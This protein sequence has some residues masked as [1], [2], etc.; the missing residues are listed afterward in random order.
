MILAS[1]FGKIPTQL[2]NQGMIPSI[3]GLKGLNGSGAFMHAY[4]LL[5][6]GCDG[7][8]EAFV[9]VGDSPNL[10]V[11]QSRRWRWRT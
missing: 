10:G 11:H 2:N 6:I 4:W 8:R 3:N 9:A 7:L 1:D 5:S